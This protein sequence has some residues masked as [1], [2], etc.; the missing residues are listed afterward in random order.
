MKISPH[1]IS[2]ALFMASAMAFAR[3]MWTH[4]PN[5]GQSFLVT[6]VATLGFIIGV[7]IETSIYD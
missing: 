2:G 3:L 4:W 5:T 1:N 6:L 7:I